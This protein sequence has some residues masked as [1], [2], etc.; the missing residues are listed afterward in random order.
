MLSKEAIEEF[1]INY[2]LEFGEEISDQKAMELATKVLLL[3]KAVYRPI[4]EGYLK[5]YLLN[6]RRGQENG[7]KFK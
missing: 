7:S 1:K 6:L 3:V 4:P 5:A 2:C